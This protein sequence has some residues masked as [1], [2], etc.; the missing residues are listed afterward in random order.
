M[1]TS[2]IYDKDGVA[3]VTLGERI[4]VAQRV[5]A[6]TRA[7]YEC[8]EA[9][10]WRAVDGASESDRAGV[11]VIVEVDAGLSDQS[12]LEPQRVMYERLARREHAFIASTAVGASMDA[13]A[14]RNVGR[15]FML[16]ATH[17]QMFSDVFSAAR[18]LGPSIDV[19]ASLLLDAHRF[20]TELCEQ[21]LREKLL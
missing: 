1:Q 9:A 14:I 6:L 5:R 7:S 11:W 21:S 16:G 2:V 8:F 3:I 12:A 13:I 10:V 15:A 20:T 4:V 18:W 19:S 17:M